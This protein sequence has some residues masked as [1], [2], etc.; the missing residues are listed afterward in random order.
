MLAVHGD[1]GGSCIRKVDLDRAWVDEKDRRADQSRRAKACHAAGESKQQVLQR[2]TPQKRRQTNV[3]SKP[4]KSKS[5]AYDGLLTSKQAAKAINVPV[6]VIQLC[7]RHGLVPTYPGARGQQHVRLEDFLRPDFKSALQNVMREQEERRQNSKLLSTFESRARAS[8][9]PQRKT[10]SHLNVNNLAP[11]TYVHRDPDR[12]IATAIVERLHEI[13]RMR[14]GDETSLREWIRLRAELRQ[15]S[16]EMF[17]AY[18]Q[19]IEP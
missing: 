12:L 13:D 7:I 10:T 11:S 5:K 8:T 3:A 16:P 2:Q 15:R 1:L 17:E 18:K 9:E 4:S 6:R 19:S 14:H